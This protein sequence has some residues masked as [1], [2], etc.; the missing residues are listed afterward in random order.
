MTTMTD[1]F[2]IDAFRQAVERHWRYHAPCETLLWEVLEDDDGWQIEA[3]PVFQEV[4]GGDQ[5]GSKVWAGFRF[6][7]SGLL[8]E[9]GV[10]VERVLAASYCVE[11]AETPHMGVRGT[12]F[13]E[14]FRLKL[15][16]EPIPNTE[17]VEII[18]T[19]KQQVRAIQERQS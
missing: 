3:A 17:P 4:L 14:S 8:A 19:L 5:D 9:R 16:L 13:G 12:Y 11:C 10:L 7:V 18:D 15:H 6:D 1:T 2:D